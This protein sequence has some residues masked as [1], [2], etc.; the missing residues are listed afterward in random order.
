MCAYADTPPRRGNHAADEAGEAPATS[1]AADAAP[2]PAAFQPL[3]AVLFALGA[4]AAS[5]AAWSFYFKHQVPPSTQT[6]RLCHQSAAGA[7]ALLS[8]MSWLTRKMR[9][10]SCL[11]LTGKRRPKEADTAMNARLG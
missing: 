6:S 10:R 3:I 1:A 7:P 11:I 8:P 9:I 4:V 2:P 5:L